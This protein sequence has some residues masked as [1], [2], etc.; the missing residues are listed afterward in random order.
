MP[1]TLGNTTI[2]GLAAG[3][4]PNASINM[5]NINASGTPSSST[6]LR[7]DGAW[8]GAG[9]VVKIHTFE[10]ASRVANPGDSFT[11][12]LFNYTTGFVPVSPSTNSY[13]VMSNCPGVQRGQNYNGFGLRFTG[14]NTVDFTGKGVTY[15]G[16]GGPQNFNNS[17]FFIN[18]G[19][20]TAGTSSVQH[21]IY[22][23]NSNM[24]SY[25]PNS[26]DDARLNQTTATL[27]I[28]EFKNA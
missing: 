8:A 1:I 23:S 5:S 4:F 7:G 24:N 14:P 22:T 25:M 21:Y 3:C 13:M 17:N 27:M 16:P 28:I 26:S 19:T 18:A 20:L 15:S 10:L 9:A 11:G 2:T 6:F 12:A